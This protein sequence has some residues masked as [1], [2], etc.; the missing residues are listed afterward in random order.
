MNRSGGDDQHRKIVFTTQSVGGESEAVVT[1]QEHKD[2]TRPPLLINV[3][4]RPRDQ[5]PPFSPPE[6]RETHVIISSGS[7]HGLADEFF[8]SAVRPILESI[9]GN[10]G[11]EELKVHTTESPT[12]ILELTDA[13][14]FPAANEGRPI[15]IILLS[16][17]GG[18][19][20]LVN[21]L[22]SKTPNPQ[23][24]IPPQVVIL[25]LG[26]ANALYHS[27]NAGGYDAWGLPALTSWKTKPLPTFTA[28]FSP[29]ARL[30]IDE[31]R[32]EQELPKDAQ[33]NG[34]LHGA[35]VASWG[36]HASLV[37]DSDTTEYRKHG[38]ERFKMAAK[39]ALYPAD[40]SPPHPYKG[41]VS[42]LQE[43]DRWT[44]LPEEEHMYILATM[45]SHLEKP[46]CIS[47][48]TKPLDGSMHLVHFTPRSGDEVMGIMNKAYDGGKHVGDGDVRYACI[49][50]L[51][52]EFEGKEEDGGRW[53]RICVDGKIV[54]LEKGGW[55]EVRRV[56]EGGGKGV[57]DV[58]VV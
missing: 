40:G 57:L 37:G 10:K 12:S 48:A 19:V 52:I 51:R 25:P 44:T 4:T 41:K 15:R 53:R 8:S 50:G 16:G 36:M 20:D 26:T 38:V 42:I 45:V 17:D 58:V 7:G 31:G 56:R 14:L 29:G 54:R 35:V 11:V 32:Q 34:I 55:V 46:F 39:E 28:T 21:G 33:G 18:I 27:I 2:P 23:I 3:S 9:Y 47:P 1:L 43:K 5:Q 49:D 22:S 13:V 24:Y 30:L 6:K